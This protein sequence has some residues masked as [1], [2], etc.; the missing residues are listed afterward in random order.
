MIKII[1]TANPDV[2]IFVAQILPVANDAVNR[3]IIVLN[4]AVSKLPSD[5]KLSSHVIVVNQYDGFDPRT[6]T[7]D[8]VHPNNQGQLKMASKWFD[9]LREVIEHSNK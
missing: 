9:A 5:L 2:V 1:R 4:D 6:D 8:G 3:R 7:Y